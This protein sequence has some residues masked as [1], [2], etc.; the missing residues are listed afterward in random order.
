MLNYDSMLV[1]N[2]V[3]ITGVVLGL[4]SYY[5]EKTSLILTVV[6]DHYYFNIHHR[7]FFMVK[8]G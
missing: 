8:I 7:D 2:D 1:I 4:I 6:L 5:T 3:S